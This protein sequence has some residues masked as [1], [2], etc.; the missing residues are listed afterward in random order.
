M[1]DRKSVGGKNGADDPDDV[2]E[3]YGVGL[4]TI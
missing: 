3:V 4:V 2:E 1:Y